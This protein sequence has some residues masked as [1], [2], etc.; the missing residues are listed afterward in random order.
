MERD[1]KVRVISGEISTKSTFA[2]IRYTFIPLAENF[3]ISR[4]SMSSSI[5]LLSGSL[6]LSSPSCDVARAKQ[7]AVL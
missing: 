2:I 5:M 4:E 3:S 6:V 7:H 1:S